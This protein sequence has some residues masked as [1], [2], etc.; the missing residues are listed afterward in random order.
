[1]SISEY[2]DNIV[3]LNDI[4]PDDRSISK[5]DIFKMKERDIY[6]LQSYFFYTFNEYLSYN[7]YEC[8]KPILSMTIRLMR[9]LKNNDVVI[10]PGDSPYKLIRLINLLYLSHDNIYKYINTRTKR[11]NYLNDELLGEE[12]GLIEKKITFLVFPLSGLRNGYYDKAMLDNYLINISNFNEIDKNSR[13]VYLDYFDL[14]TSYFVLK[15]SLTRITNNDY[16]QLTKIDLYIDCWLQVR[17]SKKCYDA[18]FDLIAESENTNSRCVPRFYVNK[19]TPPVNNIFRCNVVITILYLLAKDHLINNLSFSSMNGE[20]LEFFDDNSGIIKY[21]DTESNSVVEEE[22][23]L[24]Y[25]YI[26]K[27]IRFENY[28]SILPNTII[29][30]IPSIFYQGGKYGLKNKLS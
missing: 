19:T 7:N 30:F 13:L 25:N 29:S 10:C 3:E 2:L 4:I 12:E 11:I 5:E 18:F 15:S 23:I 22:H 26:N 14:G 24:T 20:I 1:M 16:L 9:L 28:K 17:H 21:Y 6:N 27:L 8:L